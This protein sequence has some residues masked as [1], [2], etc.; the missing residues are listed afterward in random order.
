MPPPGSP[1]T[2]G[3]GSHPGVVDE[4]VHLVGAQIA[5]LVKRLAQA[6]KVPGLL[7]AQ[8]GKAVLALR[9]FRAVPP[10]LTALMVVVL[11]VMAAVILSVRDAI[12]TYPPGSPPVSG[13][14]ACLSRR[15]GRQAAFTAAAGTTAAR[16]AVPEVFFSNCTHGIA[17]RPSTRT[18]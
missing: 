7:L 4:T 11:L 5:G 3:A 18:C 1:G 9:W 13:G 17:S 2:G 15:Q 6:D 16:K 10:F 14:R 8:H 12:R